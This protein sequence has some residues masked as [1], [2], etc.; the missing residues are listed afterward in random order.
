[1]DMLLSQDLLLCGKKVRGVVVKGDE[2][3]MTALSLMKYFV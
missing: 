1:M 2:M 3:S